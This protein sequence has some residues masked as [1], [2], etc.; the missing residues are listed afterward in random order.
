MFKARIEDGIV[1]GR[2]ACDAKGQ[3]V[4]ILL[5]LE[6]LKNLGLHLKGDLQA[7][8]VI[9]EEAGGNGAL[10]LI[11]QGHK[12]D[13][14]MV[15]EP[16]SLRMHPANRGAVWYKLG[17]KGKSAHMGKY[18]DGVSAIRR[19]S[20]LS[21]FLRSM[22]LMLRE[23]SKGNPLFPHDPSPVNVNIGQI[24]GGDWPATVPA[25]CFIEGGIA[26]LPNRCISQIHDELTSLINERASS[27]AKRKLY[28]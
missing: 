17:V 22:K 20:G 14:A 2:G 18:W 21:G 25:E 24:H 4:T 10:S 13:C 11:R 23:E 7:Q 16:T 28:L 8:I 12:A 19:W 1:Y 27:W 9:E 5:A 15:L 26:F 6:A 3:V